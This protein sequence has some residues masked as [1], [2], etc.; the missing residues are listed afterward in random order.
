MK[1]LLMFLFPAYCSTGDSTIQY[2]E[3]LKQ[4]DTSPV[5]ILNEFKKQDTFIQHDTF[6]EFIEFLDK[7]R[8]ES[9]LRGGL[10]LTDQLKVL[11]RNAMNTYFLSTQ[12]IYKW[13][14]IAM[15]HFQLYLLQLQNTTED[16]AM[17]QYQIVNQIL[18]E[19]LKKI[20]IAQ[21]ELQEASSSFDEIS[22]V[23]LT[24]RLDEDFD[25]YSALSKQQVRRL[26]SNKK[27]SKKC[28]LGICWDT[29]T[30]RYLRSTIRKI[31]EN[32]VK[33][34]KLNDELKE[35]IKGAEYKAKDMKAKFIDE[36]NAM[37][38]V[39]SQTQVA[40][41]TVSTIIEENAFDPEINNLIEVAVE[42]LIKK[43]RKFRARHEPHEM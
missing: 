17:K 3:A 1:F 19:G 37:V 32:L 38:Y 40:L 29:D 35:A 23:T 12:S 14:G 7:Y 20:L 6:N 34:K 8:S 26:K 21:Q 13:S 4:A 28:I 31:E 22:E 9:N 10:E 25:D 27:K 41:Y 15:N 43:C 5:A 36:F 24:P 16:E 33:F 11:I 18:E 42:N 39:K 2:D 30:T